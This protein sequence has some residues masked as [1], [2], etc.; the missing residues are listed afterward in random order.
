MAQSTMDKSGFIRTDLDN[1]PS[2]LGKVLKMNGFLMILGAK[3]IRNAYIC[4][5]YNAKIT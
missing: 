3:T 4:E 5:C 2:S 1:H